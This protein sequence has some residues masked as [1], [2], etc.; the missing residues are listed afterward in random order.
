MSQKLLAND[1]KWVEKTSLFNQDFI[2]NQNQESDEGYFLEV[3]V[4]YP[5]KLRDLLNYIPFLPQRM[6]M[7]KIEKLISNLHD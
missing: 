3:D 7:I 1:F 4:S 6:K 5:E 2:K